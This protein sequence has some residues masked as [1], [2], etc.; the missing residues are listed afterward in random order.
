MNRRRFDRKP[1]PPPCDFLGPLDGVDPRDEKHAVRRPVHNR[2]ALQ[3]CSQVMRTLNEVLACE[4]GDDL[5]RDLL[6]ESVVPAPDAMHLLVTLIPSSAV[7]SVNRE[8]VLERLY[9]AAGLLRA[10][11]AAAIHRRKTPEFVFRIAGPAQ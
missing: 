10:E 3:L 11:V 2:K 6:V 1:T 8:R 9:Q 7:A 4:T 5:L